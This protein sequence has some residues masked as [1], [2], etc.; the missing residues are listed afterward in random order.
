MATHHGAMHRSECPSPIVVKTFSNL[1]AQIR[2]C[3]DDLA[4]LRKSNAT[5]EGPAH[6]Q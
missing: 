6:A 1:A 2:Q 3:W 4:R 5:A